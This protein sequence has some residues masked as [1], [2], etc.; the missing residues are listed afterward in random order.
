MAETPL[1][2]LPVPAMTKLAPIVR[3]GG[4]QLRWMIQDFPRRDPSGANDSSRARN[5]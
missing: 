1:R 5:V 2:A 3:Y 4:L